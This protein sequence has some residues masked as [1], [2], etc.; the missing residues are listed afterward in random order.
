[1]KKTAFFL[2]FCSNLVFGTEIKSIKFEGLKQLSPLIATEISGLR[3]GQTITG[4]NTNRAI[5]KLFEQGYFEDVYIKEE[6][7]N[8]TIHVK[9]KPI[10]AKL[11]IE[12]VVTNDREAME[13]IIG[14]RPGQTYDK[15][16][17]NRVK[18]R[19]KQYYEVKGYFDTVVEVEEKPLNEDGSSLHL[20]VVVNR[21]ENIIIKNVNLVGAKKLSYSSIEPSIANK[22]REIFG[23]MWGFND[24][25][26]KITELPN[27]AARIKDEYMKRG[28]LEA[29]VSSPYLNA[30]M[31]NYSAELTYYIHEGDRYR[32]SEV[33]IQT[34]DFL[35]LDKES[36]IDDFKLEKGDK[37][38]SNWLRRDIA[39]LENIVADKGYAYVEIYPDLKPNKEDNTVSINYIVNP[40]KEI[41]I[42]NVTISGNEKTADRVIRREMYLTEG[43]LYNRSD[44]V[45]SQNSLRRTGYFEDVQI[46]ETRVNENEIDLN[47][48]VKEGPT[49]SITGGIGYGSGDGFL[50]NGSI[51][52]KNIFG[53]GLGGHFSIEK[54]KDQLSTN[55]G[56]T[57]PRVYDSEW[58]LGGQIYLRNSDWNNYKDKT[59]GF[60]T[61]I[62]RKLGRYTNIFLTYEIEKSSIKGLDKY[63]EKAGYQNGDNLKSSLIPGISFNNTDDYFIPR[64]G[65][66]ASASLE[67]AGIGGNTK[68]IKTMANLNW[69]FGFKDYIGW[70][71]IFRYRANAGYI[72]NDKDMPVNR[73]L[74]LGGLKSI[75]GFDG[76]SIPKKQICID[77]GCKYI[78]V[79]GNKSFNN[80]FELSMPLIDRIK[81]R[82]VVFFDYGMIGDNSWNEEK[83]HSTGAGI[84]WTTAVGPLQLFWVKPFNKKPYDSANNFEF[85]I[86]TR[87]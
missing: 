11:D 52:E 34:P 80:S 2:I 41:Y 72:F 49:G 70:D 16:A 36:I 47:V 25:K 17:L 64:S 26:L 22:Q 44:L 30:Y 37:F 78:E 1:M 3:I 54:S 58:S 15:V 18:Q 67:Y 12:G 7:G 63:Y 31:N 81:M 10:I 77:S 73:K 50:I 21:G 65:L 56:L 46:T 23:W 32:V 40:K 74:F 53:S 38:N 5:I 9:E 62:G 66:I 45:D 43:Q 48:E 84:E 55:I 51:S 33:S 59:Y 8:I 68:Y 28:Y 71:L 6:N 19:V 75:R 79:G 14:L 86:G 27:D 42:R 83:R 76:R 57:N 35:D 85:T 4:Q 87:F 24:G 20:T 69:Y 39:K 13:Q 60:S 82:F 29:E 61:T